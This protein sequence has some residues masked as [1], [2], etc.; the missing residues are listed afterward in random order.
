M[1]FGEYN[2]LTAMT[3][4]DHLLL[5]CTRQHFTHRHQQRVVDLCR[6]HAIGWEI[7]YQ[8]AEQHRVAPLVYTNLKL[9]PL[10]ELGIP[11]TA[12]AR[13]DAY[14]LRTVALKFAVAVKLRDL[15]AF[16]NRQGIDVM[17]I[18]GA[19]LEISVYEQPWYV[20][21]DVDLVIRARLQDLDEAQ[22]QTIHDFFA[23]LHGFEYDFF[24]HHDV[25]M[26]GVLPVDF[27]AIWR[28]AVAVDYGGERAFVM[29]PEDLLLT[30]CINACRKRFFRLKSLFDIAVILEAHSELDWEWL[31]ARAHQF[32]CHSIVYTALLATRQTLGCAVSD[33]MLHKL[34]VHPLRAA[35]TRL[36][37]AL[38]TPRLSLS[39]TY[40]FKG[41][42]L[43]GRRS[44]LSL[45]LTY[46]SYSP[47]Q[48]WK[49]LGAIYVDMVEERQRRSSMKANDWWRK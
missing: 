30:A 47:S 39:A 21:H 48:V 24:H 26:N 8:T 38:L 25:T 37:L 2:Y 29:R 1:S 3:P 35:A 15:F 43:F 7:L 32:K 4:E 28:E 22:Q 20:V 16:F 23:P 46:A 19:A 33:K 45:L 17:L 42:D 14:T 18:K 13:F 27:E 49:K 40:P 12:L 9:C 6:Q 31:A 10:Q 5:V 36:L 41:P 11:Q 44:T 34:A